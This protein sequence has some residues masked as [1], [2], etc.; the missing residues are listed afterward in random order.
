MLGTGARGAGRGTSVEGEGTNRRPS[1]LPPRPST[2]APRP[3]TRGPR[4][5]FT[6]ALV[7]GDRRCRSWRE[8]LEWVRDRLAEERP[9]ADAGRVGGRG[10]LFAV[11][12]HGRNSLRR[13]WAA[14]PSGPSRPDSA[15]DSGAPGPA[16]RLRTRFSSR[17][18]F[19]PGCLQRHGP[20]NGWSRSPEF[21]LLRIEMTFPRTSSGSSSTRS[22]TSCIVAPGPKTWSPPPPSWNGSPPPASDYSAAFVEQFKTLRRRTQR[23]FQRPFA[24]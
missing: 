19:I 21:A 18:R 12:G 10:R 7:A 5:T 4:R 8:K 23:V 24:G 3:S 2:L 1:P 20:F 15:G 9:A 6:A 16:G 13:R 11:F 17:A 14:F 22:R